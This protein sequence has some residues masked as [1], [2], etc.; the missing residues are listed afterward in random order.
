[1]VSYGITA[2]LTILL[3][4]HAASMDIGNDSPNALLPKY[5]RRY[6]RRMIRPAKLP[7]EEYNFRR[8]LLDCLLLQFADQQIF[9]GI[10]LIVSG[11][12]NIG[13]GTEWS[14]YFMRL[15]YGIRAQEAHFHLIVHLSCLSRSAA[16]GAMITSQASF[17]GNEKAYVTRMFL[18]LV[19]SII[20]VFAIPISRAFP[21]LFSSIGFSG[22]HNVNGNEKEKTTQGKVILIEDSLSASEGKKHFVQPLILV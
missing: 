3:S 4:L 5:V 2:I 21:F 13:R 8:K 7:K 10:A 16:F 6:V 17:K 18:L 1:M 9:T 15:L 11:Y 22:A 20:L 12:L 19:F 14:E